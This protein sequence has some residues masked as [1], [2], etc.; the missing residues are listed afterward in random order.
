MNKTEVLIGIVILGGFGFMFSRI[1]EDPPKTTSGGLYYRVDN[2]DGCQ[3]ILFNSGITHKG[4]CTNHA[5]IMLNMP[6]F[7]TVPTNIKVEVY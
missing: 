7:P 5:L 6:P 4:N 3:Y 2:I 1:E